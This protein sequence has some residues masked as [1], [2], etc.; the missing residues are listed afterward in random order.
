MGQV[1][2]PFIFIQPPL[3]HPMFHPIICFHPFTQKVKEQHPPH[4]K[5]VNNIPLSNHQ[6]WGVGFNFEFPPPFP[7]HQSGP[8]IDPASKALGS[9]GETFDLSFAAHGGPRGRG[10]RFSKSGGALGAMGVLAPSSNQPTIFCFNI[11]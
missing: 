5:S 8:F 6:T 11:C 2:F 10:S 1:G 9:C 4:P 3:C 7:P